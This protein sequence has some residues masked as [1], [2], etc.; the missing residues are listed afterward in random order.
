[1]VSVLDLDKF[2]LSID[3][4][5]LP[6]IVCSHMLD[7]AKVKSGDKSVKEAARTHGR[8][9]CATAVQLVKQH[10][11]D[12]QLFTVVGQKENEP[13]Q[14][15]V[16]LADAYGNLLASAGKSSVLLKMG[17]AEDMAVLNLKT[18]APTSFQNA[19]RQTSCSQKKTEP[20]WVRL[21]VTPARL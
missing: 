1:M 16:L 4:T 14:I 21:V 18:T 6:E 12:E 2:I 7:L 19:G 11:A 3:G 15:G 13:Q 10:Y 5:R 17:R 9:V 20:V 8:T